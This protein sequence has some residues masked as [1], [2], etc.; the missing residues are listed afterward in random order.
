V[1]VSDTTVSTAT[2][3]HLKAIPPSNSVA[4]FWMLSSNNNN[5]FILTAPTGSIIDVD[6]D[7]IVQDD[8][9]GG[10]TQITVA[11]ATLGAVYYLSLDPN[12]THRYVPV[13]LTTT[14]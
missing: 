4:G 12:A 11:T 9:A 7:L 13:S 3:A 10:Q 2:P 6:L 14:T 8:D 1:E 5:L